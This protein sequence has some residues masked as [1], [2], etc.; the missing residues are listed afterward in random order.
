MQHTSA[1]IGNVV[2]GCVAGDGVVGRLV[3][4]IHDC[5]L[6]ERQW[7]EK[8]LVETRG[9]YKEGTELQGKQPETGF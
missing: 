9:I 4:G 5:F 7:I 2:G 8:D 1:V 6:C 3:D